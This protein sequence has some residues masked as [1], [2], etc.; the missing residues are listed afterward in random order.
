VS[1][2][3]GTPQDLTTPESEDRGNSLIETRWGSRGS[4]E[5][6]NA[7]PRGGRKENERTSRG[8]IGA[9]GVEW[10]MLTPP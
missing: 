10:K 1:K 9:G 2:C 7:T 4:G 6:G 8:G 5:R 3:N